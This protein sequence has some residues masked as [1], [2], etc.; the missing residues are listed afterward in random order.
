MFSFSILL[1]FFILGLRTESNVVLKLPFIFALVIWMLL[2]GKL[3]PSAKL[4]LYVFLSKRR[5]GAGFPFLPQRSMCPS[6]LEVCHSREMPA[7]IS[8][9]F[10]HNIPHLGVTIP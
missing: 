5:Q 7:C 9:N 8:L 3:T 6:K 10:L 4:R 1:Y 2:K